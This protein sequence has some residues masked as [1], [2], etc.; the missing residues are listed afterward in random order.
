MSH[1][2]PVAALLAAAGV[3]L[4]LAASGGAALIVGTPRADLLLGSARADRVGAGP[5]NDRLDVAGGS[6]DRVSCGRGSDLVAADPSDTI[7][8]D[9]EVVSRRISTDPYRNDGAI[10]ASEAEPDS[11]AWGPVVVA[12]FQVG[13]F[14]S[15]GARNIGFAVSTDAGRHWRSG[16]LPSLT[17]ASRPRGEFS[18][19]SDPSVAY[20]A[21]NSVWLI[22]S[23]GFSDN[24]SA[25][26]VSTSSDGLH[27]RPPFVAA[28]K[29]S[30]N[31]GIQFDKEWIACDNAPA[32][33]FRG[34][35]YL[36]YSD[37]ANLRLATQTSRDGGRTWSPAVGSPD[38]AGRRGIQGPAAPAPQPVALQN[39]VV[40]I[41]L[42]DD[43]IAVVRSTDGGATFSPE[44]MI[45][46]SRFAGS[47]VRS[48]PF[49][50][51]EVGADGSVMMAWP[52][53][54]FRT[55]CSGND[56][57][58][59]KST[60]GLTWTPPTRIPLGPGNHII[61]GLAADPAR[62]GRVAVTYYTDSGQKLDVRLVWS[63]D[64][65]ATWSRPVLLSPE[66][67]P[68]GRIA[69]SNGAM[70]GDYIST[71]FAFGRAVAVFTLAQSRQRGRLRQ[72]TYAASISLP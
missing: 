1:R 6:R 44:T 26:L 27:W 58:F 55:N 42:F 41:P 36:S 53:C 24:E 22:A 15:G 54:G 51:V 9:C 25:L 14:S 56:L 17:V 49:P 3:A 71:S 13:R 69:F 5:G 7:S 47:A 62:A 50:S 35:C 43:G 38:N 16:L 48:G 10:H 64:G 37:I 68:F 4:F 30:G 60:D 57:L 61:D 39:G 67:M 19:A 8:S 21:V 11:F 65:G 70:V 63:R 40:V 34:R 72:A 12:A 18:R 33:P 45:A 66:R 52:D 32:S 29:P 2:A 31:E 46:P 28:R 59:S 20:D 23:L